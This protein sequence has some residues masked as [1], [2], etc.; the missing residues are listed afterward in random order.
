MSD[1]KEK[2]LLLFLNGV[3]SHHGSRIKKVRLISGVGKP[4]ARMLD[5]RRRTCDIF[6][7]RGERRS[8]ANEM[9]R[10]RLGENAWPQAR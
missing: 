5:T 4:D 10:H 1:E 7:H 2:K 8:A 9:T 3:I 6:A